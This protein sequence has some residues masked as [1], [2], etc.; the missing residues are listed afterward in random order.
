MIKELDY[1]IEKYKPD[2]SARLPITLPLKRDKLAELFAEL[3]YK[4]GAEI[5][6]WGGGYSETLCKANPD[7]KLFSID[8]WQVY[9]GYSEIRSQGKADRMYLEAKER[10]EPYNCA[11]IKKFSMDAV[12]DFEPNSL[13]FVYIDGGHD[14]KNV[15]CDISEW[16]LR[17]RP[18]GI[19]S[20]H[21]YKRT[22][23]KRYSL[24]VKDVVQAYAYAL[25]IRP[26]FA[27]AG[28]KI[29]GWLWV[30]EC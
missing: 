17:V 22:T 9:E 5:G 24:H 19:V 4:V 21:D 26:W 23:R 12:Q 2:M 8:P 10:L 30:K 1:I 20:G 14:F 28:D 13:D 11:L 27:M 16:S 18:G 15:A 25:E 6:V 7:M 29:P 3:E